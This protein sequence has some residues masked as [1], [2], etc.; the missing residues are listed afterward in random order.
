MS[1]RAQVFFFFYHCT[2]MYKRHINQCYKAYDFPK[3]W[4]ESI[5]KISPC[6]LRT[7]QIH[8]QINHKNVLFSLWLITTKPIYLFV[9]FI[10]LITFS[11]SKITI[12][13]VGANIVITALYSLYMLITTQQGK[14][15]HNINNI[16]PSFTR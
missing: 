15:T 5:T 1:S 4:V 12:I 8:E 16:S 10:L 6:V 7:I 3:V 11:W 13:L 2:F 14:Y 9:I